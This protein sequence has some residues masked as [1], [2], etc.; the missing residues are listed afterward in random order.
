MLG[1]SEVTCGGVDG[2]VKLWVGVLVNWWWW[3]RRKV[4]VVM[5]V[6]TV[7]YE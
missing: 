6:V 3:W 7:R 5:I 2:V 4:Q 1:C